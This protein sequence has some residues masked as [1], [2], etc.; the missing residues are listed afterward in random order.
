MPELELTAGVIDYEFKYDFIDYLTSVPN[1]PVKSLSE[2]LQGG[3]Y[4]VALEAGLRRRETNGTRD[5]EAYHRALAY[6]D[7][8]RSTVVKFLD[9]QRLDALVYPTVRRKPAIIGEPLVN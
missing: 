5:S 7:S 2:I 6:R 4:H 3:L 9:D 8:T 1:A